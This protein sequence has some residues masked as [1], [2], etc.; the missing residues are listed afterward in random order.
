[1]AVTNAASLATSQA[2]TAAEVQSE[3][4]THAVCVIV[5]VPLLLVA[6]IVQQA[7][8]RVSVSF[9]TQLAF[10]KSSTLKMTEREILPFTFFI[11]SS[12]ANTLS[13]KHDTI[14]KNNTFFICNKF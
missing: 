12:F 1:M 3:L 11:D 4:R 8:Q 5:C 6:L 14:G 9:K 10:L 2:L 7:R 13:D